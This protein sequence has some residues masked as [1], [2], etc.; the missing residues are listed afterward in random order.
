MT[1]S[2]VDPIA[3][4][5]YKRATALLSVILLS[6]YSKQKIA[7]AYA[8]LSAILEQYAIPFELVIIDDGSEDGSYELALQLEAQHRNVR[9]FQLSRNYSSHYA[10]FAGLSVCKGGCAIPIADDEQQPYTSIVDMYHLWQDGTKVIIP[11]R[12][13][14]HDGFINNFFANTY[15]RIISAL[16]EVKF[17]KG[18]AD[19]F[20]IDREIIDVINQYIHP[21]NTSIIAEVLRLGYSPIY[22]PYERGKGINEKSRWTFRK[23]LRLFKD[24]F[25]SCSTWPVKAMTAMGVVFSVIAILMVAFYS[26]IRLYGNREFWGEVMPGWTSTVVIIAFFSGLILFS[27]GIIAEYIWRIYEEVKGRPGYIIKKKHL[28]RDQRPNL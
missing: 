7:Q 24:T 3:A 21:I 28:S 2:I 5:P 20:L 16:S 1:K 12:K 19:S 23:K 17:P 15:Y 25:F 14:R 8:K 6:Y 22:Y 27:L 26:F 18:G 4:N 9:A 13:G 10:I 11:Y